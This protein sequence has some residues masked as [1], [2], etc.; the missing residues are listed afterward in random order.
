MRLENRLKLPLKLSSTKGRYSSAQSS[1]LYELCAERGGDKKGLEY[2]TAKV[3]MCL[4]A[5]QDGASGFKCYSLSSLY[6][7]PQ[8]TKISFYCSP[9]SEIS[10]NWLTG[11]WL[12]SRLKVPPSPTWTKEE[13]SC[14]VVPTSLCTTRSAWCSAPSSAR[15]SPW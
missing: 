11:L 9:A 3:W 2:P 12:T 5:S 10:A 7:L 15:A 13:P 4:V 14:P 8:H 1:L 6:F